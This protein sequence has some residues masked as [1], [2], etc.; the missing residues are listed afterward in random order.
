MSDL[1]ELIKINRNIEAQNEEI[2]RLLKKIAGETAQPAVEEIEEEIPEPENTYKVEPLGEGEVYL[3]DG[4][5]VFKLSVNNNETS[6]DNLTGSSEI[7][8][9]YEAETVLNAMIEKG[10]KF[11]VPTVILDDSVC[12][13]LPNILGQCVD[14]GVKLV[15][16]PIRA[17]ME[18]L[19]APPELSHILDMEVYKNVENLTEKVTDVSE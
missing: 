18:L 4:S 19:G 10:I 1:S 3:V 11:D 6:I 15:Y 5:D 9:F 17:S 8:N 2:I 7:N 14:I 13:N 12:G 16:I